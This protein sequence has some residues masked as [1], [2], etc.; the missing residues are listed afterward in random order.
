MNYIQLSN[1]STLGLEK[2]FDNNIVINSVKLSEAMYGELPTMDLDFDF[3]EDPKSGNTTLKV[4]DVLKGYLVY[5]NN[6]KEEFS[7]YVYSFNYYYNKMIVKLIL[8]DPDMLKTV[9][10]TDYSGIIKAIQGTYKGTILTQLSYSDPVNNDVYQRLESNYEFCTRCCWMYRYN[11]VFGYSLSGLKFI[12]LNNYRPID[13]VN[14]DANFHIS[15]I[16]EYTDPKL[17][18]QE[19]IET[20]VIGDEEYHYN[21]N[22]YN[23]IYTVDRAYSDAMN[24]YLHN[25]RFKTSK[26]N[27][28]AQSKYL[29]PYKLGDMIKVESSQLN[30]NDTFISKRIIDIQKSDLTVYYTLQSIRI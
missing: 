7:G 21:I 2:L 22:F 14:A 12:D 11:N 30:I 4:N 25:T 19:V 20:N 5:P 23:R 18:D 8:V 27:F 9:Q 3:N 17:Y 1:G 29:F 13:E 15:N 16:P 28:N 26:L 6:Q 24:N 10:S